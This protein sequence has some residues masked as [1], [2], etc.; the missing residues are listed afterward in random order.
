MASLLVLLTGAVK[1]DPTPSVDRTVIAWV[2]GWDL[3]GL[4]GFFKGINAV[5]ANWPAAA[6]GL[7]AVALLWLAGKSREARGLAIIGGVV[8]VIAFAGDYSLGAF[9]GRPR[10]LLEAPESS[11]PSGH[12][13]GTTAFFGF[14]G[15]LAV[16][17]RLR[18]RY[19]I[20]VLAVSAAMILSAAPARMHTQVHWPSD[21]AAGY[22]LGTL[23]LL[24]VIPA[25]L[26]V[27]RAGWLLAK[28]RPKDG[29]ARRVELSFASQ[30][31]LDPEKKTATKVYKPPVLFRL[32]Y[33]LAF[34]A[35]FPYQHSEAALQAA[36]YHR[37]IAGLLTRYRFGT[38]LV[39]PVIAVDK[40]GG[41]LAL[42]TELVSGEKPENDEATKQFLEQ[43][44]E[45]FAEAGLPIWQVNPR[46]PHAYTNLIRTPEGDLKIIDLESAVVTPVPPRG[47][48]RSALRRGAF[49]VFD[50]ID[51]GRLRSH[52]QANRDPFQSRLG[53]RGMAELQ[54]AVEQ[55]EQAFRAWKDSE[56]RIWGRL[57][58]LAYRLLG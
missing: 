18:R 54:E 24:A 14:V 51:F 58:R 52:I 56:P 22:L 34:Q 1:Q 42:V 21:I 27:R 33:W 48:W 10:P 37:K 12:V 41:K 39:S 23:W 9:V 13:F 16:H 29:S 30:V 44:T 49:P 43:V 4:S 15:F 6:L 25:F 38:D 2:S 3:P 45:T 50:D 5:T 57:I 31:V 7:L 17:W 20:P 55:G 19:L 36:V 11:F 53:P 46:N 8:G 40:A 47:R 28:E 35:R 32:L 26:Y